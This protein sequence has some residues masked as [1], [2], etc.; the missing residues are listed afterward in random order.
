MPITELDLYKSGWLELVFDDRNKAYGAYDLRKHYA[1]NLFKALGFTIGGFV[2]LMLV[3]SFFMTRQ[4][5]EGPVIDVTLR[6]RTFTPPVV[7]QP[8]TPPKQQPEPPHKSTVKMPP[9]VVTHDRDAEN[10]PK[11]DDLKTAD[12]GQ[13]TVKGDDGKIDIPEL[14]KGGG[15][16]TVVTEETGPVDMRSVEVM[17]E[18][19]GGA[20]A[21]SKFLQKNLRFPSQAQDAGV[22]G[23]VWLSFIVEK[24]GHLSSITV[25]RG[26]GY[27]M[28]EE[29]LRVLKL[30]PAWKPGI[31][32]GHA[33][34]VKF[35]LPFNFQ[36]PQE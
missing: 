9:F 33:V 20:A 27:G 12:P 28:D 23:K 26:A 32:N 6:P 5:K 8:V 3:C 13:Q 21:W 22:G 15:G 7:K 35:N 29:A 11:I 18:P 24:D 31:Q 34:R 30:A 1:D 10:P 19:V 17:P 2:T 14:S 16:T 4:P 25:E 36:L